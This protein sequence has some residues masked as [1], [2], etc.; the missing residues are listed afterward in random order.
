VIDQLNHR[1]GGRIALAGT[2][3]GSALSASPVSIGAA[4]S[5]VLIGSRIASTYSTSI[6][7]GGWDV[8]GTHRAVHQSLP[9][10]HG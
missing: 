4:G 3:P 10:V 8:L 2:P 9:H 1:H 5:F 6:K 7:G